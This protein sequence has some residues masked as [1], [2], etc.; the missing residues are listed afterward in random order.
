MAEQNGSIFF[1]NIDGNP[2]GASTSFSWAESVD[3]P[4]TSNRDTAGFATHLQGLRSI[5]GSCDL[6]SDPSLTVNVE[7]LFDLINTR[8]DFTCLIIPVASGTLGFTGTASISNLEMTFD[9]EQPVGVSFSFQVNG[10][11]SKIT[12]S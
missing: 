10:Q 12:Q 4:D 1:L 2:V 9:F 8:S 7:E 5:S 3:L 6:F 11:W